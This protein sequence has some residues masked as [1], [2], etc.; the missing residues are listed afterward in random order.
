MAIESS[1][2]DRARPKGDRDSPFDVPPILD[3]LGGL[4]ER[5]RDFWVWLGGIEGRVLAADLVAVAVRKPVYVCGLARSGSTLLH[6]IITA[7]PG[8]ASHRLKDYPLIHTPY[9]WRRASANSRPMP[10]RERPH[11]D[12]MLIHA[13]S[14]DAVEEMVWMAFFPGCHDPARSSLLGGAER[15]PAFEAYYA[16]HLRKLLLVE[17]ATRYAAKNNYHIA[18]IPYL[19]HL[20]PDARFLLPVREPVAHIASLVRQQQ[21]FSQGQRRHPRARAVMRRSGHFEFGLDRRPINL[22]DSVHVQQI[23]RHWA[24]GEEVRGWACYWDM[25]YRYLAELLARD[26]RVRFA[27]RTLRFEDLCA[28]PEAAIRAMLDHADLPEA[29][30]IVTRFA[31]RIR[32]PDYYQ[33]TFTSE[34]LAAIREETAATAS[35]WGY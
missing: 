34:E 33:A 20:F 12:R 26:D 6:E 5:Y 3:V 23:Q 8:V 10:P 1:A 21:V 24:A 7:H 32:R 30:N 17:R 15:H 9:W 22:G 11:G 27:V 25:V 35:L 31:G 28:N 18:R 19:L 14:P 4:V 29:E 2:P 16:C 13:E